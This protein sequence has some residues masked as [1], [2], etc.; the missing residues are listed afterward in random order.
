MAYNPHPQTLSYAQERLRQIGELAD[1][2]LDEVVKVNGRLVNTP[3][4][5]SLTAKIP[6]VVNPRL[7]RAIGTYKWLI[8]KGPD[9]GQ[10]E[11][12][13]HYL[14]FFSPGF[15]ELK[16]HLLDGTLAHELVHAYQHRAKLSGG[17]GHTHEF[18]ALNNRIRVLLGL[19]ETH[20]IRDEAGKNG[21]P[22][23]KQHQQMHKW[24]GRHRMTSALTLAEMRERA[25]RAQAP[26]AAPERPN[27]TIDDYHRQ[28]ALRALKKIKRLDA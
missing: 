21:G 11:Y 18:H 12:Q 17:M 7:R 10:I 1:K 24:L 25:L 4:C 20:S 9:H 27:M 8:G 14:E 3:K 6:L 22:L 15:S 2:H 16:L 23:A 26:V 13:A 19:P 5:W 28:L